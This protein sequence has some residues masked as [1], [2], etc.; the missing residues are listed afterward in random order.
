MEPGGDLT[1][2]L[3]LVPVKLLPR[4]KA[5][6]VVINPRQ[7]GHRNRHHQI[8]AL[9]NQVECRVLG[10]QK[11]RRRALPKTQNRQHKDDECDP[12]HARRALNQVAQT[13]SQLMFPFRQRP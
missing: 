6:T 7:R 10:G 8:G 2:D 13:P 12:L 4:Q 11:M 9:A 5:V 3:G 1:A